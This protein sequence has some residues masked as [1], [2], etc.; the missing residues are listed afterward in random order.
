MDPLHV[1]P[2]D[3]ERLLDDLVGQPRL[4][5]ERREGHELRAGA[6]AVEPGQHDGGGGGVLVAHEVHH[7]P[8]EHER[9]AGAQP[10]RVQPVRRVGE[11]HQH[12]AGEHE[13]HL[14]R[15]RVGVQRRHAAGR[16]VDARH[17]E[18][19]RVRARE[20]RGRAGHRHVE[21]EERGGEVRGPG[22]RRG[23]EVVGARRRRVDAGQ[24]V[25]VEH[26][27]GG[28][29]RVG[30][31]VVEEEV[32]VGVADGGEDDHDE[33]KDGSS[34]ESGMVGSGA[35]GLEFDSLLSAGSVISIQQSWLM[36]TYSG[37]LWLH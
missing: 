27:G 21:A 17:G 26:G 32:R 3:P 16:E 12:A 28:G 1:L 20:G 6:L 29:G 24:A 15:A 23:R 35:H 31:A 36:W 8:R 5:P 22:E 25:E 18:P 2:G 10:L 13:R 37:G 7:A 30:D 33:R 14:R 19:L 4:R 11:P 9:L 34:D